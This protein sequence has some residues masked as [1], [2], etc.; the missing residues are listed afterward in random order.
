MEAEIHRMAHEAYEK[1]SYQSAAFYADKA[2]S[3]NKDNRPTL[4]LLASCYFHT[5]EYPR[6]HYILDKH[7]ALNSSYKFQVLAAQSLVESKDTRSVSAFC[8]TR[9][10]WTHRRRRTVKSGSRFGRTTWVR[11]TRHQSRKSWRRSTTLSRSP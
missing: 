2:L 4:Y 11:R 3:L 5:K 8:L 7:K 10:Q 6:V 1:Q 9:Y